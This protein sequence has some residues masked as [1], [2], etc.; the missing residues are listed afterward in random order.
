MKSFT[1]KGLMVPVFTPFNEDKKLTIN[2]GVIDMYAG[3]LKQKGMHA[4]MVNGMIGE[5]MTLR[6]EE[7]KLLAEEWFKVTRKHQLT[8]VLNVG[9]TDLADVQEMAEHAEKLGV[10]AI[11]VLPDLFFHPST[12]E[13]LMH[14]I[15]DV[16]KH[17]PTTPVMYYHIPLMTKIRMH[18]WR[19]YDLA[20][21]EINNFGGIYY[22]D[23]NLEGAVETMSA[24]RTV[25]M[26]M[27]SAMLASMS[28]GFGTFSMAMM[29]IIP[30]MIAEYHQHMLNYRLKEAMAVHE[31]IIKRT[32]DVSLHDENMIVKMK[33]EFNK[34]NTGIKMGPARL[35]MR[36]E[37]MMRMM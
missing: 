8:M 10:D 2:Y 30:E 7:R 19:L 5:G 27:G 4:V 9:G 17:A 3:H 1:F 16:A 32:R 33:M 26:A 13:D 25:I 31:K 24:D 18:M 37:M 34:M 6:T 15:R 21:K 35:P 20:E 14:Y 11:M 23:A 29:N 12:E 36:T 22:A 28:M